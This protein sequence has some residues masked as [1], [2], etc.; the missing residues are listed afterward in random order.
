M[1]SEKVQSSLQTK[2]VLFKR[3][4]ITIQ[5]GCSCI[6]G[7]FLAELTKQVLSDL[8]ASKYQMAEYRISVYGRKQSEWD[9]L[10]SWFVNNEI[11]S[12]NAVWLIQVELELVCKN[13]LIP[14]KEGEDRM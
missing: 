3:L 6:S 14:V 7:R 13:V 1:Y 4:I 10:A 11:Y 5:S 9:Q 2:E 12:E 8:A